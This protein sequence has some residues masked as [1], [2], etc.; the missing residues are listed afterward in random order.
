M[1]QYD[2]KKLEELLKRATNEQLNY[3]KYLGG[4]LG[5]IGGLVIWQPM[6][7]LISLAVIGVLIYGIDEFM[8]RAR[9]QA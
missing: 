6:L 3:I 9:N 8:F 4:V 1:Q 2:E 7:S 5:C